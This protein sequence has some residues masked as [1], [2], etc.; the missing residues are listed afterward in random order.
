MN[1]ASNYR[2][3]H[4]ART[5]WQYYDANCKICQVA[6]RSHGKRIAARPRLDPVPS[7]H[8]AQSVPDL[9]ANVVVIG[10]VSSKLVSVSAYV[11]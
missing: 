8:G 6:G 9:H 2:E 3:F 4:V 7:Q 10:H 1:F 11:L 5:M